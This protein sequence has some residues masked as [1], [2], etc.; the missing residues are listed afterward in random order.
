M[1]DKNGL[2]KK[3]QSEVTCPLCLQIFT[4]PKKLPCDHVYC[5]ACLRGL[6]LRSIDGTI[7]CPECRRD[8]PIPG[9]GVADFPTPHQVN[10]LL[11]MYQ[12]SLKSAETKATPQPATCEV[13]SSQPLTL[14]CE[15]CEKLV[16]TNCACV[17]ENHNHGFID[18]M[19][20]R[21]RS[22][23]DEELEPVKKMRQEMIDSLGKISTLKR[24]LLSEKEVKLQQIE[25]HFEFLSTILHE[26]KNFF[27]DSTKNTFHE[28]YDL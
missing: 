13:H 1:A 19:A 21:Y 18:D 11:E 15:T 9:N 26:E 20:K 28:Q 4:D 3:L 6:A 12:D 25:Q 14:Y 2:L 8:I 7:S 5:R 16:C 17:K 22:K 27:T 10:R 23:L 24:E